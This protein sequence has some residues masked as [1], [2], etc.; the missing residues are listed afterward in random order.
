MSPTEQVLPEPS[1]A[2]AK[3]EATCNAE[4]KPISSSDMTSIFSL[5]STATVGN[6]SYF[7]CTSS[8]N[9][10]KASVGSHLECGCNEQ[11]PAMNSSTLFPSQPL[12]SSSVSSTNQI[13]ALPQLCSLPINLGTMMPLQIHG[14]A[15][16]L[17][18]HAFGLE[19]SNYL[20]WCHYVL[21]SRLFNSLNI[22][23]LQSPVNHTDGA[24]SATNEGGM[25]NNCVCSA[26]VSIRAND[27]GLDREER[28]IWKCR[29]CGKTYN[30]SASLR[31]HQHSHSR[32]WKCR[33]C[34]KAFSRK[35]L[36]EGHERTHTGEKP[37]IC[38]VCRR[39]F[40][41]RSNMR[42]HMQTHMAV[43]HC[44]CPHCPRSFIRRDLL[45][46][47]L[48]KCPGFTLAATTVTNDAPTT[49]IVT[50]ACDFDSINSTS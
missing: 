6:S 32:Q 12:I 35:W 24:D 43:K 25:H 47:H 18:S 37:F 10:S 45:I 40:A 3:R 50:T 48:K 5:S 49:G 20:F 14:H 46:R 19:A 27:E 8:A 38:P 15:P 28:P 30:S 29:E 9:H 26:T 7:S 23:V 41:D 11:I 44:R 2:D 22:T 34:A 31:M 4:P 1:L 16:P 39:G 42:T 33:F 13:V 36:L 17:Q 21:S